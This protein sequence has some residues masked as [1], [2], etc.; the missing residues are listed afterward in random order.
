MT[1]ELQMNVNQRQ[2]NQE[3]KPINTKSHTKSEKMTYK[4]VNQV[5]STYK[6][7][8]YIYSNVTGY[9]QKYQCYMLHKDIGDI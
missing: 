1:N 9:K 6:G 8:Y 3:E 2:R 5:I 7:T 4:N